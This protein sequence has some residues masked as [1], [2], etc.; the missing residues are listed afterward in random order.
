MTGAMSMNKLE[1]I[2]A[3]KDRAGLTKQE[4]TD[5]DY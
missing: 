4:S 1:L 5:N 2:Q 3:I